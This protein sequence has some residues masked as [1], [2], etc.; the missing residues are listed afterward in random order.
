M[1]LVVPVLAVPAILVT[2]LVPAAGVLAGLVTGGLIAWL[3]GA[4]AIRRLERAG[5]E[6]LQRLRARPATRPVR[7]KVR[8]ASETAPVPRSR[9]VARNALLLLGL[10]LV[11]PQG[12][13]ALILKL[14]GSVSKVWFAAL[15][16]PEP[17][18]IPAAVGAI[19]LGIGA[20]FLAWRVGS[21]ASLRGK[22]VPRRRPLDRDQVA[23]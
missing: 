10:L 4:V 2:A 20:L 6:T 11:F 1:S 9:A 16:L 19:L 17:W 14:T 13:A 8:R 12:L 15:Y 22:G 21:P 3:G 23:R 5:P 18:P 7:E